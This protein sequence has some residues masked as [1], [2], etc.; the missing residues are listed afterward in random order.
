M[1][2]FLYKIYDIT[3]N[4]FEIVIICNELKC[5][6]ATWSSAWLELKLVSLWFTEHISRVSA[7][8]C[9]GEWII[10]TLPLYFTVIALRV[11]KRWSTRYYL[12]FLSAYKAIV[13]HLTGL[14]SNENLTFGVVLILIDL[15][16]NLI[17]VWLYYYPCMWVDNVFSQVCLS[18]CLFRL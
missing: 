13:L 8:N 11:L 10:K 1:N 12:N 14:G 9:S 2:S 3:S 7:V 15:V 16:W 5:Q 6:M 18:V 4:I 17:Y